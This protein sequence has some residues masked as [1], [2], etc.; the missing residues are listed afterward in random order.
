MGRKKKQ[1]S[2]VPSLCQ[3]FL[4]SLRRAWPGVCWCSLLGIFREEPFL[5]SALPPNLDT[6]T[7]V[8]A[9]TLTS[10]SQQRF[11]FFLSFFFS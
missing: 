3:L 2:N 6:R 4:V 1:S 8:P 7:T 9:W 10:S 11:S 5:V